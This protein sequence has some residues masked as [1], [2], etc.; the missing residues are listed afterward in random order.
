MRDLQKYLGIFS[1]NRPGLKRSIFKCFGWMV[2]VGLTALIGTARAQDPAANYPSRPIRIIVPFAAGGASDVLSRILGK[3]LTESWGQPVIVEN[4][5]GGNAQIGAAMVAKSEPDGYT[6]LVVDLSALTQAP[7]M[8]PNLTYSPAKDL[9]PVSVLAYSPHILV[10]ANKLP[11][12][13]YDEFI[14]YAKKQKDPINFGA[15]LGAAPHLAGVLLSQKQDVPINFIGYKGGAQAIADLAGGQIDAT[16][17]SYLATYP[18]VRS[19]NFKL[20]AVASPKRF[21]PIPDTLTLAERIPGY[22]TGSFQG[23][24]A[25]SATPPAIIQKLHDEIN[26]I[27]RQPDMQ[28][29]FADLGSDPDLRTPAELRKWMAE[30]TTYWAKVIQDGNVKLD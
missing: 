7:T 9:T 25:P 4:K 5:T 16:M 10:V 22:V 6:L 30:E 20:I 14:A 26:R 17:N 23:M 15:P 24:M 12:K 1:S 3:K 29:Q 18:M 21:T 13:T 8:M 19:G 27:I 28:K 11:V 2:L